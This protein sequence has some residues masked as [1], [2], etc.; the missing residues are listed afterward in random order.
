MV[1]IKIDPSDLVDFLDS[2]KPNIQ[3]TMGEAAAALAAAT[4]AHIAEQANMKLHTRREQFLEA[5]D[6]MQ[7]DA[8]TWVVSL[9]EK[10]AWIEEGMPARNLLED[11]LKSPKAKRS[12]DG[13]QYLVVP[14]QH[15][16]S[17]RTPGQNLLLNTIKSALKDVGLSPNKVQLGSDGKPK[18]GLVHRVDI[19]DSP[20]KNEHNNMGHGPMGSVVQGFTGIPLLKGVRIYQR[21][22]KDKQ[23]N[24]QVQRHVMT[25]RTASS[26]Q[27]PPQWD[28][29]ALEGQHFFDEAESWAK[30]QLDKQYKEIADKLLIRL[31]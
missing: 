18:L 8:T 5:L 10:A 2:L 26:K 7:L 13:S 15:N 16:K 23:G 6:V 14:F 28:V 19:Q 31:K 17:S 1:T 30:E 4:K 21:M 29:K 24:D 3:K 22:G 11:L 9:D 20:V 27:G 25:F 12:K